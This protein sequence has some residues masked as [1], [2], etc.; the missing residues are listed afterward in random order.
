MV[1]GGTIGETYGERHFGKGTLWIAGL[2]GVF[3]FAGGYALTDAVLEVV[4]S[5]DPNNK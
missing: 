1:R 3:G 5:G 4:H 2:T